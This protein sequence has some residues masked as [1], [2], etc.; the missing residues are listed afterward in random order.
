M[1][2]SESQERMAVVVDKDDVEQF[3]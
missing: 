3:L 2:I 1:A